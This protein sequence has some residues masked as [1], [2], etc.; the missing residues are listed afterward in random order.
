MNMMS[1][2][3]TDAGLPGPLD[4]KYLAQVIPVQLLLIFWLEPAKLL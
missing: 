2:I 1:V 3:W 4:T